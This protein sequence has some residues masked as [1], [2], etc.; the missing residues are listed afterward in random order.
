MN[1]NIIFIFQRFKVNWNREKGS[2]ETPT[3]S[4]HRPPQMEQVPLIWAAKGG[5][6]PCWDH[7]S[8]PQGGA[9]WQAGEMDG[10][11]KWWEFYF[12]SFHPDLKLLSGEEDVQPH[13]LATA[14]KNPASWQRFWKIITLELGEEALSNFRRLAHAFWTFKYMLKYTKICLKYG[15][16]GASGKVSICQ[17]R[18]H[19]R[20]RFDP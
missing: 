8:A 7:T 6:S 1:K 13:H 20:R 19:K 4:R 2:G 9:A 11:P 3:G 16:R 12:C 10:L 5:P 14:R 17:C 15:Y 18:R